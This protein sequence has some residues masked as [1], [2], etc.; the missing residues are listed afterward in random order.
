[1]DYAK[2][3]AYLESLPSPEVWSLKTPTQ[4]AK[5]AK[6]KFNYKII[7][8]AG[9][10][11]KGS[12]CA[13]LASILGKAGYK[14]GLYTSPH[15]QNYN[16]RIK[17][18]GLDI[19]DDDFA[20]M[21]TTQIQ[22]HIEKMRKEGNCPS[23]F[24]A[25]TVASFAYFQHHKIDFL[26]LETGMGGKLDATNIAPSKLQSITSISFDHM[27]NLG[28]SLSKI[29]SEK[30]GIIKEKSTVTTSC[31]SKAALEVIRKKCAEKQS[32]FYSLGKDFKYRSTHLD[33]NG[34]VFDYFGIAN[35]YPKLKI[36]LIGSHQFENASLALA[37]IE[38]LKK[39]GFAIPESAIRSGLTEAKWPGRLEIISKYPLILLDGAHNPDG[40]LKLR[41]SLQEIF[42]KP[43]RKLILVLGIMA[44]KEYG[45]MLS[46][47][48][49]I[50]DELILSAASISR[51]ASPEKLAKTIAKLF[52]KRKFQI[53][54]TV[55][56]AITLAKSI[57]P[58]NGCICIT[59][60]LYFVGEAREELGQSGRRKGRH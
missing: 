3:I 48:G 13:F 33:E 46:I 28:N 18:N 35:N 23:V 9:T 2:S 38:C 26:V 39:R 11:G 29:A 49:P 7:H 44:D 53:A 55:K 54:A 5:L 50:A 27:A 20:L 47:I 30:A 59:G 10:N 40:M 17:I 37:D 51:S 43:K 31:G 12:V 16:E 41:G 1:M 22:P 42:L 57:T 32:D 4:L 34:G 6:I 60:S 15:L 45:K 19:S 21:I 24:E 56:D 36:R 8:V 14:T 58:P 52:P 25:L